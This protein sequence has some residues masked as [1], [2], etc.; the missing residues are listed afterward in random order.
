[1]N[2]N[3]KE[4][5]REL[6][7]LVNFFR[8]RAEKLIKEGKLNEEHKQ[9]INACE[10]LTEQLN[11]HALNRAEI[12]QNRENLTNLI[13]DNAECPKCN[14]NTH[15]KFLGIDKNEK[16]WKNNKYKCRRCN[17]EFVWNRPN[18]PWDMIPFVEMHIQEMENKVQAEKMNEETKAQ[19]LQMLEQMKETVGKLK[20]IV[21]LSDKDFI[22]MQAR[23]LEMDKMIRGFKNHLLIERIKMDSWNDPEGKS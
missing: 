9:V 16:G 5:E 2:Q 22:D 4:N 18:N 3:L 10:R 8:K 15:L 19:S 1:M 13:K 23:E 20:P 14:K 21:E 7:K 12:L 17:I 6:I 11:V